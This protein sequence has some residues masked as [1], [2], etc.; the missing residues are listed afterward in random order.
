[1]NNTT[2]FVVLANAAMPILDIALALPRP[3]A[4]AGGVAAPALSLTY[5]RPWPTPALCWGCCTWRCSS[6]SLHRRLPTGRNPRA[7]RLGA[8]LRLAAGGVLAPRDRGVAGGE[9]R[10]EAGASGG[11]RPALMLNADGGRGFAC[12]GW[13]IAN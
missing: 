7:A 9:G 3:N 10:L 11:R 13:G 5:P 4:A 6:S 2:C 12:W 8:L 1:M